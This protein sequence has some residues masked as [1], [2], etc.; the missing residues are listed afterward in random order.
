MQISAGMH[1]PRSSRDDSV[2]VE[3]DARRCTLPSLHL[4][5]PSMTMA[6]RLISR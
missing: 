1:S 4:P 6:K 3:S 2:K 5:H